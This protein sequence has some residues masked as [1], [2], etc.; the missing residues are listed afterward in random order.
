MRYAQLLR[1]LAQVALRSRLILHHR[2]A[3]DHAQVSDL[4]QVAQN[5]I[6]HAIGEKLVVGIAA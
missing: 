2:R 3:A 4:R 6:L 1:N 5:L